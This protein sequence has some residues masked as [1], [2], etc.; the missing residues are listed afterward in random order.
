MHDI[1]GNLTPKLDPL[2]DK[3]SHQDKIQNKF[4]IYLLLFLLDK[5][6]GQ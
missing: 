5:I 1:C 6:M 3:Y 2:S 4:V